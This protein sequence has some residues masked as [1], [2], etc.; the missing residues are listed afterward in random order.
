[1]ATYAEHRECRICGA[2]IGDDNPDGIGETC[3]EVWGRARWS[4]YYH[5]RG[6]DAWKLKLNVWLSVFIET[7]AN[8]KFRSNFRRDFYASVSERFKTEQ[9]ISGKQLNIVKDWLVGNQFF[10][11]KLNESEATAIS[12]KEKLVIYEDFTTWMRSIN[13]EATQYIINCAKKYY[14]EKAEG[15]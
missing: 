7:F 5:F 13:E 11:G 2:V 15:R 12:E 10:P 9:P 8:T 3:R 4:A 14:G 1:M 6:L